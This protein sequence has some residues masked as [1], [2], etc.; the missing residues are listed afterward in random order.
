MCVAIVYPLVPDTEFSLK[1]ILLQFNMVF[2]VLPNKF[3]GG[4]VTEV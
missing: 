2:M 4:E 1:T 3:F